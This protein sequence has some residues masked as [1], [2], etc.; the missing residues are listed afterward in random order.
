M[1]AN[2]YGRRI[3]YLRTQRG[4]TQWELAAKSGYSKR[5]IERLESGSRARIDTLAVIAEAL[6]VR[7][8][9]LLAPHRLEGT[10][11]VALPETDPAPASERSTDLAV[12]LTIEGEFDEFSEEQKLRLVQAISS[13]LHV[14]REVRIVSARQHGN[15]PANRKAP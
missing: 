2:P 7:Y 11:C 3:A 5:T 12:T 1:A 9:D 8:E 14:G 6:G 13:L 10:A 4:W 15:E